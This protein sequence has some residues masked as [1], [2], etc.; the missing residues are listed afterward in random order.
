MT[1]EN[2]EK[3]KV[4][5]QNLSS[6]VMQRQ[7]FQKQILEIDFAIKELKNVDDA[8]HIVGTI[9]IKKS[10]SDLLSQLNEKKETISVK[11]TSVLKQ[12]ESLRGELQEL[13]TL[14]MA[15][16]QQKGD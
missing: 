9:M 3:L 11:I 15:E 10:A 8:Y 7:N 2:I 5:E 14:V 16:L 13:Q 4:L 6:V 1:E 12:E